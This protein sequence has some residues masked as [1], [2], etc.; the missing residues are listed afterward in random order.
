MSIAIRRTMRRIGTSPPDRDGQCTG[1]A[2]EAFRTK[3]KWL[4]TATRT[5]RTLRRRYFLKTRW[6][7]IK[8]YLLEIAIALGFLGLLVGTVVRWVSSEG[9]VIYLIVWFI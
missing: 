9:V 7:I 3:Y 4:M 5:L 2:R 6:R 1:S 8:T